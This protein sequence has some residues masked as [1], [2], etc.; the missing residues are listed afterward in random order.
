[1]TLDLA[2]VIAPAK[3]T[4]GLAIPVLE[5]RFDAEG[6]HSVFRRAADGR[7]RSYTTYT[8][9]TNP[10][11]PSPWQLAKRFDGEGR[12]HYNKATGQPVPTPHVHQPSARGGVRP[13]R[14][15]EVPR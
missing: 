12:A 8:V 2:S 11:E 4:L 9:Q 1:L 6:A 15:G 7:V 3:L 14:R 13:A 5:P 10:R